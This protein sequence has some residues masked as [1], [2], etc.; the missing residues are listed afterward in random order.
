MA[1]PETCRVPRTER[2]S[3]WVYWIKELMQIG[4]RCF[5]CTWGEIRP[6]HSSLLNKASVQQAQKTDFR[7]QISKRVNVTGLIWIAWAHLVQSG[8]VG[9]WGIPLYKHDHISSHLCLGGQELGC[10]SKGRT[11]LELPQMVPITAKLQE[12]WGQRWVP[13]KSWQYSGSSKHK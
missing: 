7:I 5:L 8:L 12:L 11:T 3:V 4:P 1:D 6:P 9:R 10:L 2:Q 13:S